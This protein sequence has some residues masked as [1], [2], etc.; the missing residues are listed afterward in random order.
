MIGKLDYRPPDAPL[1]ILHADDSILIVNKP[2]GLL[3]VP[4][5]AP[6]LADCLLARVQAEFKEALLVHRLD[7]GTSGLM[8]FARRRAAQRHIGLQF[9]RRHVKK[10]YHAR[11]HGRVAAP[12]GRIELPLAADWFNRPLQKVDFHRG[13][14]AETEWEVLSFE[15]DATRLKFMPKTGRSHQLRIHAR[16]IGHPIIG[17]PLYG[18]D[19]GAIAVG[20]LQLHAET[21]RLFHPEDG[22]RIAFTSPCPF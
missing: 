4:G 1:E 17:D 6:D 16:A 22:E 9:E 21:L 14:P 11:V 2:D 13:K 7:L 20:R 8:V 3:T 10:I 12:A 19:G 5:K 15:Q 18:F